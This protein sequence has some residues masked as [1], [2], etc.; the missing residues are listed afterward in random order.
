MLLFSS[1]GIM[2]HFDPLEL[3]VHATVLLIAFAVALGAVVMN[4]G[5]GFV[6]A[7]AKDTSDSANLKLSCQQDID[8]EVKEIADTKK[9]CYGDGY[10]DVMLENKGTK[11]ITGVQF[12]IFDN[13]DNMNITENSTFVIKYHLHTSF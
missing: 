12:V 13:S 2:N 7:T 1:S 4:W 8:L 6:E 11:D 10:I 9:I 5:K 3:Q